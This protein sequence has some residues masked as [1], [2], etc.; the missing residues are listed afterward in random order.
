MAPH[1]FRSWCEDPWR[2][3]GPALLGFLTVLFTSEGVVTADPLAM[4][5]SASHRTGFARHD[6]GT[7]TGIL[8]LKE[9][10]GRSWRLAPECFFI[11]LAAEVLARR[12][13]RI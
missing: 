4:C 1:K 3:E 8:S 7:T 5:P 11:P 10:R 12:V 9:G 13:V 6:L 2:G